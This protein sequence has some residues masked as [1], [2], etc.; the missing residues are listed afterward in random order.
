[1]AAE[2]KLDIFDLLGAIGRRDFDW[3]SKQP[4]DARREFAPPVALRWLSAV[5]GDAADYMIVATNERVNRRMWDIH[6]HP[7]LIYRLMASTGFGTRQRHK[8][9]GMPGRKKTGGKA[10]LLL[11]E[12]HPMASDREI[13]MLLSRHTRQTFSDLITQIGADDAAR[14]DYMKAFDAYA[15]TSAAKES[16]PGKSRKKGT[17]GV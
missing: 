4:E 12:L 14:K 7:D 6:Q 17:R 15:G 1:M 16:K 3:L 9:I 5:E 10:R 13:D 8:W 11:A 2:R